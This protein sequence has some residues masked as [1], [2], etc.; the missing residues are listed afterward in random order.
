MPE[1]EGA[2]IRAPD[3]TIVLIGMMGAGKTSIGRRL[4]RTLGWPFADADAEIELAAGT[5]IA[6]IF[7]EI[8]E[9]AFRESERQVIARMLMGER[10]VLAL[11]GGAFIDPLTRAAVRERATSVWLKADLEVLV[12]RTARRDDRPLLRDVDPRAKLA[13]LLRVREPI[14]QEADVIVDSSRGSMRELVREILTRLAERPRGAM[15]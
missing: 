9:A 3:T 14:Y 15:A 5:S 1:G 13:E 8:G 12:Q 10:C 11:G 2:T 7:H 6:N 4:A